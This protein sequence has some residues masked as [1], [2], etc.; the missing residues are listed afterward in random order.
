MS[1][2]VGAKSGSLRSQDWFDDPDKID[3]VAFHL[4]SLQANGFA[5]EE[6]QSGKP[7]IGSPRPAL[8][9]HPATD[10]SSVGRLPEVSPVRENLTPGLGRG[11]WK[12]ERSL[13]VTD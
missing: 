9:L 3:M 12:T 7:V 2:K 10:I 11:C 4:E 1:E 5:F 8:T 6:L 13:T